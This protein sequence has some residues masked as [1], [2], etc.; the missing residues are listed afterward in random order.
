MKKRKLPR[1][2]WD[3]WFSRNRFTLKKGRDYEGKSHAMG[4]QVRRKADQKNLSVSI[5]VEETKILV[6]IL[7]KKSK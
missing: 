6:T 1:H 3:K 7:G 2:P 5:F 4:V